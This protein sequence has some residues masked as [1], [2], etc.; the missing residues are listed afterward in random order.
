[1]DTQGEWTLERVLG[2]HMTHKWVEE[3]LEIVQGTGRVSSRVGIKS[4]HIG[5]DVMWTKHEL[6]Q[7]C[8]ICSSQIAWWLHNTFV[9]G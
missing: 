3:K 9:G 5:D 6:R 1:M 4:M 2:E 7:L 8:A